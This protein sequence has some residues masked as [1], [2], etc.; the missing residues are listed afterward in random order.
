MENIVVYRSKTKIGYRS[1]V[2]KD[3][4]VGTMLS[5]NGEQCEVIA[6]LPNDNIGIARA[7][8]MMRQ[9]DIHQ[10]NL[11]VKREQSAAN[12]KAK[13]EFAAAFLNWIGN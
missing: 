13:A 12:R 5:C 11:A 6:I 4:V 2:F 8:Q 10:H 1:Q 7:K 9:S 3:W